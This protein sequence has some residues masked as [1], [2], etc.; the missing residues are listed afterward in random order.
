[1][2]L[3]CRTSDCDEGGGGVHTSFEYR[4]AIFRNL[5][6]LLQ[7]I[8]PSESDRVRHIVD[9][10]L[11]DQSLE[12]STSALITLRGYDISIRLMLDRARVH[13]VFVLIPNLEKLTRVNNWK[14]TQKFSQIIRMATY[15]TGVKSINLSAGIGIVQPCALATSKATPIPPA[16]PMMP[17]ILRDL[18]RRM[19]SEPEKS[20]YV[21]TPASD[22]EMRHS[23]E[24]R[25]PSPHLS[26]NEFC[27]F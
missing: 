4:T 11:L 12:S 17:S 13:R 3:S 19:F 15:L 14:A 20:K 7:Q 8:R 25:T 16:T 6:L 1:M 18:L 22:F 10:I 24:A 21:V 23:G 26:L 9:S 27:P 2:T 5:T